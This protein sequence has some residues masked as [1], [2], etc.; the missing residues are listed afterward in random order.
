MNSEY[1]SAIR[2]IAQFIAGIVV[3]HGLVTAEFQQ[4]V[5]GTVAGVFTLIWAAYR[6]RTA[7]KRATAAIAVAREAVSSAHV[8]S[9]L[10]APAVVEARIQ[11][12]MKN[13]KH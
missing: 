9:P 7:R 4:V 1:E 5:A 11:E 12:T 10:N 13:G 2:Q 8:V 3:S 6:T